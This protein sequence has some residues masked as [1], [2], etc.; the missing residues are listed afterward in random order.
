MRALLT[1]LIII[2]CVG[3]AQAMNWEGHDD[4]MAELSPAHDYRA[5]IPQARPLEQ[6]S[7]TCAVRQPE[8]GQNPYEQIPLAG[9][10]CRAPA[11][12]REVQR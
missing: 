1:C 2:G 7:G 10:D 8:R 6:P 5:A 12:E 3:T 9:P 4:W 11:E